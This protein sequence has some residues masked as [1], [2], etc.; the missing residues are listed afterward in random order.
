MRYVSSL[1]SGVGIFF[2]GAGLAWYH[3]FM[4]LMHPE[5]SQSLYWAFIILGGSLLS[6]SGTL[7]VAFRE[8]RNGARKENVPMLD[9]SEYEMRCQTDIDLFE[10]MVGIAP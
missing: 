8:I 4:G 1:I 2:F 7:F 10:L 3:G 9:Y 6:E 5:T